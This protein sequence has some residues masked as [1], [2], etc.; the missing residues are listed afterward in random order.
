[1]DPESRPGDARGMRNTL[2]AAALAAQLAGCGAIF[3]SSTKP[4]TVTSNVPGEITVNGQPTGVMAPG[5]VTVN[6]HKD[7]VIG[8]RTADGAMGTC[9]L[10]SSVGAGYVILD[11][12]FTAL[13]GVI[14]DAATGSWKSVD[15]A[16]HVNV[17][18]R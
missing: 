12:V 6:N 17:M 10:T 11:V 16:C 4:V 7:H 14:V 18:P 15:D 9:A 2:I 1:M 8:V 3:N 13:L 5:V